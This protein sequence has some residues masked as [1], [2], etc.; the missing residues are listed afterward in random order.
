MRN[1]FGGESVVR[2]NGCNHESVYIRGYK[3]VVTVAREVY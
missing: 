3:V 2:D 1:H